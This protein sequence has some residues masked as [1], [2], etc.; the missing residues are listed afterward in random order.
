MNDGEAL[1]RAIRLLPLEDVPRLAYA[2]YLDEIGDSKRASFIRL[3]CSAARLDEGTSER[4]AIEAEIRRLHR[5]N[6]ESWCRPYCHLSS[7]QNISYERGFPVLGLS[8]YNLLQK[9]H[10]AASH[11][12]VVGIKVTHASPDSSASRAGIRKIMSSAVLA[13]FNVLGLEGINLGNGNA[14]TLARNP[15][16]ANVTHLDLSWSNLSEDGAVAVAKSP[17]LSRLWS[18]TARLNRLSPRAAAA[19]SAGN[20]SE[21][22]GQLDLGYT[23]L[24][25]EGARAIGRER[26]PLPNLK[27]IQLDVCRFSRNGFSF[28]ARSERFP[29]TAT[30]C[31]TGLYGVEYTGSLVGLQSLI[32]TDDFPGTPAPAAR[33]RGR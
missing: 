17:Y 27:H 25:D 18:L 3:S 1:L 33:G 6:H 28:L 19:L 31:I 14:D 11:L 21:S 8:N 7:H 26:I 12:D 2:D 16:I 20:Y 13:H 30:A 24:G 23:S 15:A 32:G 5:R 4:V 29:P 10:E 22:L 9:M